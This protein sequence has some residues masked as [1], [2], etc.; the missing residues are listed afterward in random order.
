MTDRSALLREIGE[1]LFGASFQ[2]DVARALGLTDRSRVYKMLRDERPIADGVLLDLASL[3]HDRAAVLSRLAERTEREVTAIHGLTVRD[4]ELIGHIASHQWIA[5]GDD[6]LRRYASPA[7]AL[8]NLVMVE[9]AD[10]KRIRLPHGARERI[11]RR[12]SA[13]TDAEAIE[14]EAAARDV[15]DL[16]PDDA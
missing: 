2:S 16:P 12:L 9:L 15:D 13:L 14:V 5:D 6:W 8:R 1:A 3:A 4:V 10:A 11:D 7:E